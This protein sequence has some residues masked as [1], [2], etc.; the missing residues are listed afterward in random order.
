MK[1][2]LGFLLLMIFSLTS[3]A[4]YAS[5]DAKIEKSSIEFIKMDLVGNHIVSE[6]FDMSISNTVS[7]DADSSS[8]CKEKKD[9]SKALYAGLLFVNSKRVTLKHPK[10]YKYVY[11]YDYKY[12]PYNATPLIELTSRQNTL[13][14][15]FRLAKC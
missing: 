12:F 8:F 5:S 14:K 10:R 7:V 13:I 11:N 15:G 6:S 3:V 9:K 1:R 4:G 2:L